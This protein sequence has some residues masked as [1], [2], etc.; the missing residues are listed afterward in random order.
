M[1]ADIL[2][3]RPGAARRKVSRLWWPLLSCITVGR[4]LFRD[5]VVDLR[6]HVIR[7]YLEPL[8]VGPYL[9]PIG[10]HPR[11]QFAMLCTLG[12]SKCCAK[13]HNFANCARGAVLAYK[14]RANPLATQPSACRQ[15]EIRRSHV[16]RWPSC[17]E[18][19]AW[20]RVLCACSRQLQH[21]PEGPA[22]A[23]GA[24][25]DKIVMLLTR[26]EHVYTN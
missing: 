10:S 22:A 5:Q 12:H 7:L 16:W 2:G 1:L 25:F 11:A 8:Q 19:H 23:G 24:L 26:R 6:A 3:T 13:F 9:R 21:T 18:F 15:R 14:Q 4:C 17:T 20:G